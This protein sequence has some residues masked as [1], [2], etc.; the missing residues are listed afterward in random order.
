MSI[1]CTNNAETDVSQHAL[2]PLFIDM[3]DKPVLVVGGG[4][5]ALRKAESLLSCGARVR[6]VSPSVDEKLQQYAQ[7]GVLQIELRPFEPS[8]VEGTVFVI[9]ATDDD[10][11]NTAVYEA[12]TAR[13]TLVNI[14]DVPH[15]CTAVVPSILRR[16][17]LQIAV[18]TSGAAPSLARNIRRNLE[19]QF[20]AWYETYVEVLGR[21]R[22]LVKHNV[23]GPASVRTPLFEA[24]TDGRLENRIAA[25]EQ[26]SAEQAYADYVEPLLEGAACSDGDAQ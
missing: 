13:N 18:S 19:E 26:V 12:A 8:D 17:E 23:A 21:A 4:A 7:E 10:Q 1:L 15:L 2:Y 20:P 24:L 5:V 11:V 14:V 25:G 6:V 9:G 16:G 22:N 3:T